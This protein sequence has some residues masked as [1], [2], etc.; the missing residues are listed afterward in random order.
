MKTFKL[1]IF[2]VLIS[3]SITSQEIHKTTKNSFTFLLEKKVGFKGVGVSMFYH[4]DRIAFYI[5]AKFNHSE[6]FEKTSTFKDTS[7][8]VHIDSGIR[9]G[10]MCNDGT[11]S[12]ATGS[13]ACSNHGGVNYWITTVESN[14]ISES[15]IENTTTKKT[16]LEYGIINIGM[17]YNLLKKE[18]KYNAICFIGLGRTKFRGTKELTLIRNSAFYNINLKRTYFGDLEYKKLNLNIGFLFEDKQKHLS[19]ATSIDTTPI[20][21]NFSVGFN[22]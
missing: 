13:G 2:F 5:N 1:F 3:K 9:T 6:E 10:C 14:Y 21:L 16:N 19:F 20:T 22:F 18:K 7:A 4:K 17:S 15:Q 12:D 8:N 11:M